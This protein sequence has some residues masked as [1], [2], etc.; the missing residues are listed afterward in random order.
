MKY[1]LFYGTLTDITTPGQS[2]PENNVVWFG[3]AEFYGISTL[4]SYLTPNPVY[5]LIIFMICKL[6]VCG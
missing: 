1:S 4:V 6:I 5:T 3:S 2:G